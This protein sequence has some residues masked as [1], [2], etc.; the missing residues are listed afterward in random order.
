[1]AGTEKGA[2]MLWGMVGSKVVTWVV[3]NGIPVTALACCEF[4]PDLLAVGWVFCLS[5]STLA[6]KHL[7]LTEFIAFY[8]LKKEKQ[9]FY[10]ETNSKAVT[11]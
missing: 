9:R 2:L 5:A 1:M 6:I 10:L 8:T 7:R 11:L 3:L 4:S